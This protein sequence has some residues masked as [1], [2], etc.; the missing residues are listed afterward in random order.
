MFRRAVWLILLVFGLL[1]SVTTF[2]TVAGVETVEGEVTAVAYPLNGECTRVTITDSEGE[3]ETFCLRPG[4]AEP[5]LK[6]RYRL[7]VRGRDDGFLGAAYRE[8][9]AVVHEDHLQG[10]TGG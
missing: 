10:S 1:F 8:I 6:Q 2:N 3:T 4:V 5:D 9:T 7:T